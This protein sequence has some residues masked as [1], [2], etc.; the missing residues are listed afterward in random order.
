MDAVIETGVNNGLLVPNPSLKFSQA[1]FLV[2]KPNE[3]IRPI[4]DYS[5]WTPF[6]VAPLIFTG[7]SWLSH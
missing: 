7:L 2:L 3:K 6:I 5:P 1:M 4:I